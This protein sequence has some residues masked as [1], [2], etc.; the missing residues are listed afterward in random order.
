MHMFTIT[1][2]LVSKYQGFDDTLAI[3]DSSKIS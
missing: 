1:D 3:A 2:G